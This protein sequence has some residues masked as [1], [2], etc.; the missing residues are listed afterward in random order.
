M[1]LQGNLVVQG[2]QLVA[3]TTLTQVAG[4]GGI[5]RQLHILLPDG[6]TPVAEATFNGLDATVCR[7]V[8]LKDNREHS[9]P[10][11]AS[12]PNAAVQVVQYLAGLHYL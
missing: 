8:T 3:N 12:D 1:Y 6:R 7:V 11:R 10:V 5:Q 9:L 4:A 2:G